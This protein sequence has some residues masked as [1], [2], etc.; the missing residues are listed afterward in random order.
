MAKKTSKTLT[1]EELKALDDNNRLNEIEKL[2]KRGVPEPTVFY[3][4]GDE[5]KWGGMIKS[6]VLEIYDNGKIYLLDC[7]T[8]KAY[9]SDTYENC[10]RIAVWY[11]VYKP[12]KSLEHVP[13]IRKRDDTRIEFFRSDLSSLLFKYYDF[14]V[15]M[16]PEYQRDLVWTETQEQ[17][18]LDSIY[19][20]IEIGKFA[21]IHLDYN[22][23]DPTSYE[24]LDGKQR[25][26]TLIKFNEGRIKYKGLTIFEMN[27]IDRYHFYHYPISF[28]E[29]YNATKKQVYEYFLK[30]NTGGV[31]VPEAHLNK[32][33]ELY[34]SEAK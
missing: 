9:S 28:G 20:N 26:N 34:Q 11:D 23:N 17:A 7:V 8:T 24:I 29:L 19:N 1:P 27:T 5:V 31:T 10:L 18:L 32:V 4:V 12:I 2:R 30:L 21:F 3:A 22:A 6:T 33:R 15:N 13:V 14:I 25:L 16:N